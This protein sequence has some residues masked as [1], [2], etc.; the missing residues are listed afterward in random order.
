MTQSLYTV[1]D[2]REGWAS[3]LSLTAEA[4]EELDFWLSSLDDYKL[5]PI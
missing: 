4:H 3:M 2:T 1:L 5:Q